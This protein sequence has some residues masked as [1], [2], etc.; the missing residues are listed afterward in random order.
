VVAGIRFNYVPTDAAFIGNYRVTQQSDTSVRSVG[1][2]TILSVQSG[3]SAW[4]EV[5]F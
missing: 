5:G 1:T 2:N 4:R 3:R